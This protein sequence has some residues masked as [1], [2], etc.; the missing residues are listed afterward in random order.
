MNI[1]PWLVLLLVV[2]L[3]TVGQLSLKYAFQATT[4]QVIN[5]PMQNILFSPYFWIWFVS[6]VVVTILWLIVLRTIPLSQAF[7]T[8]GLT[9][10]L[11]PLASYYFLRE[12]V[13]LSQWIGIAI[14][15]SG[16]ILVVQK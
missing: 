13:V 12:N 2:V 10:A 5:K 3:G 14:I 6:Y 11:V 8:L 15:V 1:I 7:P 9:F 16:V 4:N